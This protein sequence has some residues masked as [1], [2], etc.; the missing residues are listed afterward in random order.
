M[1]VAITHTTRLAY[2]ADVVEGI[3]DA[4]LG[5]RSDADQRWEQFDLRSLPFGAIRRYY[6]GFGNTAHLI[7][8]ARPHDRVELVSQS[9]VET[10]L[11]DPFQLPLTLPAPLSPSELADYLTPSVTIPDV[12]ALTEMAAPFT[13]AQPED[14][15]E[16]VR[17]MM[18]RVYQG[19]TYEQDVTTV[20]TTVPEV[21]KGRIG[22]CQDFAHVLIGLCRAIDVPARYVSGY[23]VSARPM[24]SQNQTLG[25]MTQTQLQGGSVVGPSRGA[26]ASHAWVEAYT[27]THGWRGFDPTNNLLASTHHVKMAIGRDYNDVPPTR[28]TFRG[29]AEEK[30]TVEVVTRDLDG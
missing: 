12:P 18:E 6:D 11:D 5:P 19:F 3:M 1:R 7:T 28:G 13:P 21:L 20:A 4:R 2:G 14:A 25:T 9:V 15:F 22:V 16:S 29:A 23:I 26:G 17:A 24:Q 8:L 10:L 27:P 30:L